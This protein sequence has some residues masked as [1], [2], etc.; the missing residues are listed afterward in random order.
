MR[1]AYQKILINLCKN[2][3]KRITQKRRFK[4]YELPMK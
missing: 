1:S 2:Y 3:S 4:T